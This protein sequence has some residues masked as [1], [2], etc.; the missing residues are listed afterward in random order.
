MVI[1]TLVRIWQRTY[2]IVVLKKPWFLCDEESD[3][4]LE[5]S[6]TVSLSGL[7]WWLIGKESTCN[8]EAAGDMGST[9]G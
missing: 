3:S 7:P 5:L 9:P 2:H 1:L 6:R 4:P 8:S